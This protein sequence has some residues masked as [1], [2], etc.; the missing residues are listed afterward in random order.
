MATNIIMHQKEGVSSEEINEA[1]VRLLKFRIDL[2]QFNNEP[3]FFCFT[4]G[5]GAGLLDNINVLPIK[6]KGFTDEDWNILQLF[7]HP[8]LSSKEDKNVI[9]NVRLMPL[10]LCQSTILN[11]LPAA[12]EVMEMPKGHGMD[13][14]TMQTIQDKSLPF[15][16]LPLVW[17]DEEGLQTEYKAEWYV[18]FN[19]NDINTLSVGTPADEGEYTDKGG[20]WKYIEDKFTGVVLPTKLAQFSP[21]YINDKEKNDDLNAQFEEKIRPYF[22]AEWY[23]PMDDD[24]DAP[25][26]AWEHEWRDA[27]KQVRFLYLAGSD[28]I[29]SDMYARLWFI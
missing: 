19:S 13:V 12:G 16:Q 14:A 22:P 17:W 21:Y 4:A 28:P 15:M 25:L 23:P 26:F 9:W 7:D 18:G 3:K 11:S 27:S 24:M 8:L 10:D 29:K 20:V 6:D 5:D 2:I 1:V